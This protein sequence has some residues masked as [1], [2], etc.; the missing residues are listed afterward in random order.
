VNSSNNLSNAPEDIIDI[1]YGSEIPLPIPAMH[2][3]GYK[4]YQFSG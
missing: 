4:K 3:E 1:V 2:S